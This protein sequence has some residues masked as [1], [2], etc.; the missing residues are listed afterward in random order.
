MSLRMTTLTVE[1]YMIEITLTYEV[2]L[3]VLNNN[4]IITLYGI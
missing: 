3:F 4:Y 1:A 2:K